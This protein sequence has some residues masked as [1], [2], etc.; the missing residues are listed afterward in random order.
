M[1]AVALNELSVR[2]I[3]RFIPSQD[4]TGFASELLIHGT[5][6][7]K[8]NLQVGGQINLQD[9]F[10]LLNSEMG[11]NFYVTVDYKPAEEEDGQFRHLEFDAGLV[12]T[13]MRA[14]MYLAASENV[15]ATAETSNKNG[16]E[17]TQN[18][19]LKDLVFSGDTIRLRN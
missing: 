14:K 18:Q 12:P 19:Q 11:A 1:V 15:V 10:F 9:S 3:F 13:H 5:N 6:L 8:F 2:S 7:S 17:T 16:P 4:I